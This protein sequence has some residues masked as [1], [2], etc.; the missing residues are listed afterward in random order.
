MVIVMVDVVAAI[1]VVVGTAIIV[2]GH[3]GQLW[4]GCVQVQ[5]NRSLRSNQAENGLRI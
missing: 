1:G 5:A 2:A 4:V 3:N